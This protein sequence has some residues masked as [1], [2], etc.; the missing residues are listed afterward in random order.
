MAQQTGSIMIR[1]YPNNRYNA[2]VDFQNC[3]QCKWVAEPQ[4]EQYAER[5]AYRLKKWSGVRMQP[6]PHSGGKT[7]GPHRKDL[8]HGCKAGRCS[9]GL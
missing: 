8:C 4:M 6:P 3:K 2:L 5:V 7:K 9:G 1:R